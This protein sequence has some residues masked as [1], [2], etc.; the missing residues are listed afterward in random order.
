MAL[1]GCGGAGP[2]GPPPG[3]LI[4]TPTPQAGSVT[5]TPAFPAELVGTW[6]GGG[7]SGTGTLTFA[8]DGSFRAAAGYTGRATVAGRTMTM[9]VE[10]GESPMALPWSLRDGVLQ[11]GENIYLRDDGGTTG[12]P[13]LVGSWI[14]INGWTS[15]RFDADGSFVFEDQ[16]NAE[17][18]TGSYTL[19]G[20]RLTLRSS[21]KPTV[22]YLVSL[23]DFLV[24]SDTA[25]REQGRY[26]RV[27]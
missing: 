24:F 21:T 22:T 25:G 14:N 10:G 15:I 16:A 5:P 9:L 8:T 27:G 6:L 3:A 11:I 26:T 23:D 7:R 4:G 1:V 12:T 13:L 18:V 20:E 17:T 2:P 19:D